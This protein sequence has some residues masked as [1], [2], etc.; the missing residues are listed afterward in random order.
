MISF[1]GIEQ[2]GF[3]GKIVFGGTTVE[4]KY[5][6]GSRCC[7]IAGVIFKPMPEDILDKVVDKFDLFPT[8]IV[9]DKTLPEHANLMD[10]EDGKSFDA[11]IQ[12]LWFSFTD[13]TSWS[14]S[15]YN[16]QNSG[17]YCHDLDI[18]ENGVVKWNMSI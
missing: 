16:H 5:E 7:E 3:E 11:D 8:E 4:W 14:I 13:G 10:F 17:Y 15:F 1:T 2:D 6:N 9:V 12:T 18:L